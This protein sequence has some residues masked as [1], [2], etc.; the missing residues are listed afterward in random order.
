[1]TMTVEMKPSQEIRL[2]KL[3]P[4]ACAVV[5]RI[6]SEDED[7]NRLKSLGICVGRRVELVKAGDPLIVRVFGSRLGM[8]AELASRVW[9]EICTPNHCALKEPSC[10]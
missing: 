2:D 6:E 7:I 1:M 4:H 3:Q 8:S 10:E 5:R 9:L